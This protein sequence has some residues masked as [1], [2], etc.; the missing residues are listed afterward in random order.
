MRS[1]EKAAREGRYS[2]AL[3]NYLWFHD[4]ALEYQPSLYGV[5]L[6]F[7]LAAWR[8]LAELYPPAKDA[9]LQIRDRKAGA[10]LEGMADRGAFDDVAAINHYLDEQRSTYELFVDLHNRFP[11]LARSCA[12]IAM[13]ALIESGDFKLA[14]IFLNDPEGAI[15]KWSSALHEDISDLAHKPPSRAPVREAFVRIYAEHVREVVDV[16]SAVGEAERA[17]AAR[18]L[19]LTSLEDENIRGEVIRILSE[20][21][22]K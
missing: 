15:R 2:E 19:A 9:L 11:E 17:S 12:S 3:A 6:S 14:R 1:G 21:R 20:V 7:A 22:R 16:L 8:E 18:D 4:H 10:L 5:R 13:P